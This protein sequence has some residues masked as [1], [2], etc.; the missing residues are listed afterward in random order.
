MAQC[1]RSKIMH[2]RILQGSR[3]GLEKA[4]VNVLYGVARGLSPIEHCK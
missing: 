4:N 2:V 1:W 3:D